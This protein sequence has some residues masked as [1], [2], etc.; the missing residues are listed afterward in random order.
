MTR[1]RFGRS[2]SGTS[3]TAVGSSH[4]A[5]QELTPHRGVVNALASPLKSAIGELQR[6]GLQSSLYATVLS[7]ETRTMGR[8]INELR[9]PPSPASLVPPAANQRLEERLFDATANVKILTSQIAMHLEREWR[10]KLFRQVD[11]LHDPKEWEPD[12]EPIQQSSF[13]TFLKAVIQIKPKRRP[14]L[15]LSQGGHLIAAWTNRSDRL[16]IEFLPND[17]VRWVIG[18]F[19][20]DEPEHIAGQTKVSRLSESLEPYSPQIWFSS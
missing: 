12:D 9:I 14:G 17:R 11:S 19:G 7:E 6:F 2:P 4:L 15:G 1:M 13:A 3:L 5:R 16:T 8:R 18:R 10:D 20:D